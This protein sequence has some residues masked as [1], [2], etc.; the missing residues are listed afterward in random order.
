MRIKL[1]QSLKWSVLFLYITLFDVNTILFYRF[2]E[3][4]NVKEQIK[5]AKDSTSIAYNIVWNRI[6]MR[7]I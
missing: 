2:L 7:Q 6:N 3:E 4:I 5:S 1:S